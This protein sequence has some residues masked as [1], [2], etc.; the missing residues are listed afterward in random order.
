MAPG[1]W[2]LELIWGEGRGFM[3]DYFRAFLR[4]WWILLIAI[5]AASAAGVAVAKSHGRVTYSA[6]ASLMVDSPA[7]P[8]LRTSITNRIPQAPRSKSVPV[9]T[10]STTASSGSKKA[11]KTV[12]VGSKIVDIPQP[13]QVQTRTP[14]TQILV[15]DANLYPV[16]IQSDQVAALRQQT[17]AGSDAVDGAGHLQRA[18]V[19]GDG[20]AGPVVGAV[21]QALDPGLHQSARAHGTRFH[22]HK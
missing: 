14:D 1:G 10:Q 9:K 11:S 17:H 2:R 18:A 3:N 4:F 16:L 19:E 6:T 5:A 20:A 21:D 15:H 7:S 22:C 13:P 8:F 12:T